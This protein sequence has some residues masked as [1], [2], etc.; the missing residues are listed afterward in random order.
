MPGLSSDH[1]NS[2]RRGL[3]LGGSFILGSLYCADFAWLSLPSTAAPRASSLS[4]SLDATSQPI[5]TSAENGNICKPCMVGAGIMATAA[6]LMSH[7]RSSANTRSVACRAT[8]R[9]RPLQEGLTSVEDSVEFTL[10]FAKPFGFRLAENPDGY[11]VGILEIAYDGGFSVGQH[12]KDMLEDSSKPLIWAQEGDELVQVDGAYT[13]GNLEKA[14]ELLQAAGEE[15]ELT[16][17]RSKR[18]QIKVVFPGRVC[19]TSP[20]TKIMAQTAA[21]L[22]YKCGCTCGDGSCGYCWHKD[23]GTGEVYVLPLN[24]PGYVPSI[25]R[26]APLEDGKYV[27]TEDG[28]FESWIPLI[29][30][31]APEAFQAET[32]RL[33]GEEVEKKGRYMEKPPP[34]SDGDGS[35][36]IPAMG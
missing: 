2:K 25:F 11:G 3:I 13:Q 10:K 17:N 26:K 14:M 34:P 31:P 22:G 30:K 27:I 35:G 33:P 4:P 5:R 23:V 28:Q 32:G 15:V 36:G 18:G 7:H 1:S 21:E 16:F 12:F 8:Q 19:A 20:R 24:I 29:L 9:P 6:M